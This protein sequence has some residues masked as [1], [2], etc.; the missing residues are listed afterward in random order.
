MFNDPRLKNRYHAYIIV[1]GFESH[2]D[3]ITKQ[4]RVEPTE[5]RVKG[6]FRTIGKKKPHKML[7]KRNSWILESRLPRTAPI[8][9]QI[10][11][12]LDKIK[13]FKQSFIEI[14]KKYSLELTCA[15]YYYEANPGINLKKSTLKEIGEL[16]L[17]VGLD[18][19]CL[20]GTQLELEQ[21]KVVKHLTSHLAG[22]KF[23]EKYN[24][25]KYDENTTLVNS[26]K[27]IEE[28]CYDTQYQIHNLIWNYKPL[29]EDFEE[30]FNMISGELKKIQQSIRESKYLKN[31]I[32]NSGE[33][34]K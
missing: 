29:D 16:N 28:A 8:E 30:T 22:V 34:T 11:Q 33:K 3:E 10:E 9:K 5:T 20:A 19:Y 27:K 24:D 13:P 18:I 31:S 4:V 26:L 25:D 2:P 6:E 15:I 23:I 17:G 12:L 21:P 7:N 32:E 1:S 14:S